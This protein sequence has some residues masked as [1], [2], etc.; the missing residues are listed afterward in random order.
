MVP[1][2]CA[3]TTIIPALGGPSSTTCHSWGVKSAF[4][5]IATSSWIQSGDFEAANPNVR[6]L[7]RHRRGQLEEVPV[8]ILE[9]REPEFRFVG[10]AWLIRLV[11]DGR[12]ETLDALELVLEVGRLEI[13]DD[14]PRHL[15]PLF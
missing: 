1:P 2:R 5:V 8:R 11:F 14:P 3:V 4:A 9:G 13:D 7:R 6:L 15:V 10:A 12:A